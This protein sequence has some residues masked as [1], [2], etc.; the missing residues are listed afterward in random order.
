MISFEI[1][2]FS[3]KI[4]LSIHSLKKMFGILGDIGQ[5]L[6]SLLKGL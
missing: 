4:I 1:E 3:K 5:W 2:S 6:D